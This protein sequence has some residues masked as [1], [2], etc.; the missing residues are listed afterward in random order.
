MKA[1]AIA[2]LARSGYRQLS[3]AVRHQLNSMIWQMARGDY[4]DATSWGE[5]V[6]SSHSV[7][8]QAIKFYHQAMKIAD[9]IENLQVRI[10]ARLSLTFA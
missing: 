1:V 6:K 3:P 7:W 5:K 2:D 4:T 10:G 9:E 8:N